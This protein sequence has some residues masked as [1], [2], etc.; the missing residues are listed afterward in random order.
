MRL[1]VDTWGM[2]ITRACIAL[3]LVAC[4]AGCTAPTTRRGLE[5]AVDAA[6]A[7]RLQQT[8]SREGLVEVIR[9]Q[10][11]AVEVQSD[12]HLRHY[13][14]AF[15]GHTDEWECREWRGEADDERLERIEVTGSR[16]SPTDVLT[17]NQEGGVD[18][19]DFIKKRGDRLYLLSRGE[20]HTLDLAD[21]GL[22]H[23]Q[24]LA[25][26][27]PGK[28]M[29]W[30]D[31]ILAAGPWLILLAYDPHRSSVQV[32][33]F[34][35]APEGLVAAARHE[36]NAADYFS[37]SNYGARIEGENLLLY[38]SASIDENLDNWLAW[39]PLGDGE[40]RD[41]IDPAAV[42]VPLALSANPSLHAVLRCPVDG[43]HAGLH[44]EARGVIGAG[45]ATFY[46]SASAGYLGLS[47]WHHDALFDP[48]FDSGG[49]EMEM[50][51]DWKRTTLYRFAFDQRGAA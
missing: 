26:G 4:L 37:G 49:W 15:R 18:E 45:M 22:R 20:L 5:H 30:F 2:D 39:R 46:A 6:V 25:L 48:R 42:Y 21:G 51:D 50:P 11:R 14:A 31:E 35:E 12:W 36:I 13:C 41:L 40:W 33:V 19:G 8:G 32:L 10:R 29:P 47:E 44:C 28:D 34:R 9:A 3:L 23:T 16:I 17:N 27:E 38:L 24:K 7:P 43:L 1:L